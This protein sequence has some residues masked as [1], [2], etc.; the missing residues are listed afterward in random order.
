MTC[1]AGDKCRS[2]NVP[3]NKC[4]IVNKAQMR[5]MWRVVGGEMT[6]D[7]SRKDLIERFPGKVVEAWEE[8]F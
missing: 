8:P 4:S 5:N 2:C 6:G 3:D 7:E 1:P